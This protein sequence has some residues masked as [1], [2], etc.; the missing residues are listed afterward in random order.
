MKDKI[1]AWFQSRGIENYDIRIPLDFDGYEVRLHRVA[2]DKVEVIR[3]VVISEDDFDNLEWIV[4]TFN[5][6]KASH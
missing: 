4:K 3:T 1:E 2:Q 5:E 6:A